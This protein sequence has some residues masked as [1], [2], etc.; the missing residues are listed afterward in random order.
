MVPYISITTV[1]RKHR[2]LVDFRKHKKTYPLTEAGL[3]EAGKDLYEFGCP[4]WLYSSCCDFPEEYGCDLDIRV[5]VEKGCQDRFNEV[6]KP[7][8][9]MLK[10]VLAVCGKRDFQLTLTPEEKV[11]L[12]ELQKRI[13]ENAEG[14]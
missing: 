8:R 6:D 1:K 10:K 12:K 9:T 13:K 7:R 14:I 11:A 2:L 3:L 5:I 4:Q